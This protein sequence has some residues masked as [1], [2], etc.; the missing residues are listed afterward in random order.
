[1]N[2]IKN[3]PID[4]VLP[5]VDDSDSTWR[6]LKEKNEI[7]LRGSLFESSNVRF[8]NW[9]N[10][11]IWFRAVEKN[12]PWV[13]KIFLITFGHLP[14]FLVEDHPKLEIVRHEDYI[15]EEY[16][17]TFNSNTI[18]MNLHRIKKLSENFILFNDDMFPMH[19]T[20]EEYYFKNDQVCDEAVENIIT[21]TSFGAVSNVIRYSQ[22]NNMFIINKYFKKREVQKKNWDKWYCEDY[23][24]RLERTKSLAYWYDFPGFYDPHLPS[25]MKKTVLSKLWELEYDALHAGSKNRFRGYSDVTQYLIRYWQLCEGDFYPRKTR[26]KVF[27]FGWDTYKDVIKEIDSNLHPMICLNENCT[28]KQFQIIK[29]EINNALLKKFPNKSSFER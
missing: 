13:H 10:L 6:A 19:Y 29:K 24:D 9:D 11:N 26:G 1:M 8:Q 12:M 16:L 18:E 22:V 20:E 28:S 27:F 23:E 15:P 2:N 14:E 7:K 25:A 5:W 21:T 17:P 3:Q 4:I